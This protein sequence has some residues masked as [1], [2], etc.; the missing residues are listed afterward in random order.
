[1]N[2]ILSFIISIAILYIALRLC[3]RFL[4][5]N[6]RFFFELLIR[7]VDAVIIRPIGETIADQRSKRLTRL[8]KSEIRRKV[9][10]SRHHRNL[11]R[12]F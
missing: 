12:H 5:L 7:F 10:L 6:G 8:R 3:F 4:R 1:V 9:I 2:A 11:F